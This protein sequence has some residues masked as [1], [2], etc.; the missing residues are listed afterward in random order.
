MVARRGGT[1]FE[2]ISWE[3]ALAA[4]A[5]HLLSTDP[6]RTFFYSSG[7]SSNEAAFIFQLIA[8]AFG[9]A[10]VHNCSYYCHNASGVGLGRALGSGTGTVDLDDLERADFAI[11]LG[12][13]PASNHPR[14]ITQLVDLRARW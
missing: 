9:T 14:L 4:A 2:R 3:E 1:R 11:V 10:N 12:A 13:N 7:R 6:S 8:R 5:G